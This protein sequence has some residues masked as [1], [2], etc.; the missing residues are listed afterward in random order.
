VTI[1]GEVAEVIGV[2]IE[3]AGIERDVMAEWLGELVSYIKSC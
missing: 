3:E 2:M 1:I